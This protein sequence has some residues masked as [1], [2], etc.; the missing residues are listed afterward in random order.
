MIPCE[1]G[2]SIGRKEHGEC[3][4]LYMET[5]F[6]FPLQNI[7]RTLERSSTFHNLE[8]FSNY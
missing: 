8:Q 5:L 7:E 4:V 3:L 1:S 6:N 2:A